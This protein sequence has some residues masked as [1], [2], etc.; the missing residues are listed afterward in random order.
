MAEFGF[1]VRVCKEI[2]Q[3]YCINCDGC[4]FD[5]KYGCMNFSRDIS[6]KEAAIYEKIAMDYSKEN[7]RRN[8]TW[9]ELVKQMG[10]EITDA[11]PD[12]IAEKLGIEFV[13]ALAPDPGQRKYN[14]YADSL[15]DT[16]D[17]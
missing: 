15:I 1:V 16:Q 7:P 4:P 9:F 12:G 11:V 13:K 10:C 5:T 14:C 17:S 2:C 8:P 3:H 6:D